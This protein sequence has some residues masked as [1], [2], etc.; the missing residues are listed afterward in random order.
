[1]IVSFYQNREIWPKLG[2]LVKIVRFGQSCQ[3]C[4]VWFG[5]NSE[6]ACRFREVICGLREVMCGFLEV[7]WVGGFK[8]RW[9]DRKDEWVVQLGKYV[10]WLGSSGGS[11]K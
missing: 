3:I 5:H 1:M 7:I 11:G 2:N 6:A 4:L 10:R 8:I 9:A